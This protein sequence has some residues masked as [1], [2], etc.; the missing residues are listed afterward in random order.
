MILARAQLPAYKED[1]DGTSRR[2]WHAP[3]EAAAALEFSLRVLYLD[4]EL[5]CVQVGD[6]ERPSPGSLLLFE[7][8]ST[9]SSRG[10]S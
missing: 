10:H 8:C 9:P 2:V 6:E 5:L 7:S 4:Q 1:D 3:G